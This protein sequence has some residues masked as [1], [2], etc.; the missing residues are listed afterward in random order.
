MPSLLEQERCGTFASRTLL[1]SWA[2]EFSVEFCVD[3]MPEL[4]GLEL[5]IQELKGGIT[6][7]LYRV[8]SS[9]GGDYVFRFYGAK[10][11]LFIDREVEMEN[12]R[13]LESSGVTQKLVKYLPERNVTVVEFIPGYVLKN[14]DF[15]REDLW[16]R[17]MRPIRIVHQSREQLPYHFDP[18][19]EV[20][21]FYKILDGINP[22]YPEFDIRGTIQALDRIS[23]IAAIAP[24]KYVPCHNDLL[25]DNFV[26]TED[27]DGDRGPMVLIDWEYGGMAPPYYDVADM[28]Q[29]VLVP[30]SVERN[31]LRSYWEDKDLDF[32]Q[33]M[34]DLYKPFPDIYWFLWSL[35][36]LNISM[37]PFD[38]YGYGKVKF[39]N[40]QKNIAYLR[41]FYQA[42]L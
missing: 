39:E 25:A 41:D 35:I 18:L 21:R 24:S 33:Y 27:T 15:L 28:F 23:G 9:D 26:L 19:S 7:R 6:N 32:H 40:A 36:Q 22:D 2:M 1:E 12:L 42:K 10:T 37:I 34:T 29:E 16:E 17:I 38:Y 3:L 14:P 20:K 31:L 4:K 5:R 11:E 8:V 30:R 13:R